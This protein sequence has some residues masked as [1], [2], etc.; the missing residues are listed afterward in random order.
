MG[1]V[2]A[3]SHDC[4]TVL[5]L[6]VITLLV[7]TTWKKAIGHPRELLYVTNTHHAHSLPCVLTD[8][9]SCPPRFPFPPRSSRVQKATLAQIDLNQEYFLAKF[10]RERERRLISVATVG[11]PEDSDKGPTNI[12]KWSSK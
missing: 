4:V 3:H 6:M 11:W 5:K 7:T 10:E 8:S 12:S 2:H 1:L 9:D